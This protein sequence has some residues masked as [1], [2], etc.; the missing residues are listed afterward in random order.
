MVSNCYHLEKDES[1]QA[2]V[3]I[4]HPIDVVVSKGSPATLN[5]AARPQG[6]NITWFKDGQPVL[7]SKEQMNSHRIVLD[8]GALFLLK[9]NSGKN[10][11]DG[12]A[13]S[14]YCVAKNE[15]GEAKSNE[16]SLKLAM[17]REDFRTRPRSVQVLA[18]EKA[19]LECTP[20]KGFPEPV[21]SWRKDDKELKVTDHPTYTLHPDGNLI[22]EPV[23][24]TDSG[25]F[26]CVASNMV[27]ERIS[28]PARLS[29]YEKPRFLQE[30]K[31]MTVDSGASVLFDCRVTGEPQPQISWKKKGDQMPVARAYIAKDN[32]G[33]R[34][35]RVQMSD[36]GEYLCVARNPAGSIEATAHLRVQV[37]PSFEVK[38]TDQG[39]A[40]GS[41][42]AFECVLTGQPKPAS[43]WSKEGHQ[44]LLFPGYLSTDNRVRVSSTGTLTIDDVR[45]SDEGSYVCAG[46]NSAGSSLSKAALKLTTKR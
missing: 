43:F 29:V 34:I 37:P 44:D 25:T 1:N 35:D 19:T 22:I 39:V 26:Q 32:Q 13:G 27:G 11:K 12:D 15:F 23:D 41:T 45:Q 33:L 18:G 46:M 14:Y 10:G 30:P 31:D 42:A 5:C 40:A 6:A 16:G 2:P 4:E 7:T 17:L 28:P 38:P 21:V 20:P 3:I 8:T 24:H 36:E 9:V